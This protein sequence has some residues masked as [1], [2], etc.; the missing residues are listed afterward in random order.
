MDKNKN[1]VATI[2]SI[3]FTMCALLIYL[4][5]SNVLGVRMYEIGLIQ[6]EENG[7]YE[8]CYVGIIDVLE[9]NGYVEGVNLIIN[10]VNIEGD[11]DLIPLTIDTFMAS[12]VDVIIAIGKDMAR[13]INEVSNTKNIP[14]IQ[15]MA[16]ENEVMKEVMAGEVTG[17]GIPL[18]VFEQVEMMIE[19]LP[20]LRCS[21]IVY[22]SKDE[23]SVKTLQLYELEFQKKNFSIL[24][25]D[26]SD[27]NDLESAVLEGIEVVDCVVDLLDNRN[28][29]QK[30]T[31]KTVLVE[32][33]IP[34]FGSEFKEVNSGY[35]GTVI[36]DYYKLGAQ[37][38][39]MATTLLS[40]EVS[41]SEMPFEI[42]NEGIPY[43]NLPVSVEMGIILEPS[44]FEQSI[45]LYD[46]VEMEY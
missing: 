12:E 34:I 7:I 14:I 33:N 5:I 13:L 17:V 23:E 6:L 24:P 19:L 45:R 18:F 36:V 37:I 4:I 1:I 25:I 32:N 30:E 44:L 15:A 8:E 22:D 43:I 29:N 38:G 27:G 21:A 16:S 35:L 11:R 31:I 9:E 28:N 40:E 2:V 20:D 41:V 10:K 42:I 3:I 46:S 39:T 26:V